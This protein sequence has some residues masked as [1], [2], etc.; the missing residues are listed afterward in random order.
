VS[1]QG[2]RQLASRL[3]THLQRLPYPEF[4]RLKVATDGLLKPRIYKEIYDEV[5]RQPDL[6]IVE[7]GG[8]AG[9]A[10]IAVAWALQ[11]DGKSAQVVV[12][13]K[14]EGGSRASYGGRSENLA[15]IERNFEEYRVRDRVR[16]FPHHLTFDN[17]DEVVD[18][19]ETDEIAALI[20]DAD[21]RLHRDFWFF[22]P[23]LREGG[24]IVIDDYH[25]T[26]SMKYVLTYRLVELFKEWGLLEPV[27]LLRSTLFARKPPGGNIAS[28]DLETCEEVVARVRVEFAG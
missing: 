14:C 28:L 5:R 6:D 4:Y 22:W 7:V 23:R 26:R 9:T 2:A 3:D 25:P 15:R 1:L 11:A 19:I 24:A 27:R 21:G 10:S 17:G 13:E 20:C 18:L 16:L 12:I 8:A